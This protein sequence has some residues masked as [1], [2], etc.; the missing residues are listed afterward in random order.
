MDDAS[1]SLGFSG[2]FFLLAT[3]TLIISLNLPSHEM[4]VFPVNFPC[5]CS[6]VMIRAQLYLFVYPQEW[7]ALESLEVAGI[8][9]MTPILVSVFKVSLLTSFS[10][11]AAV[12]RFL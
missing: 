7:V 6:K 8:P 5:L 3:K 1:A 10:S 11:L 9:G 4:S 12:V 2:V